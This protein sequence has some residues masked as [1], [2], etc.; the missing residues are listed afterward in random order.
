VPERAGILALSF[1]IFTGGRFIG[2]RSVEI[3]LWEVFLR[4][5]LLSEEGA[6]DSETE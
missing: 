1:F 6:V 2:G 4:G 3:V 5:A